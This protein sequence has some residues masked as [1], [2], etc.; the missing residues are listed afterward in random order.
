M[1]GLDMDLLANLGLGDYLDENKQDS[2]EEDPSY[3]MTYEEMRKQ[4]NM[5]GQ[6]SAVNKLRGACN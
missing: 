3:N 2:G 1:Y 4:Y 6:T 5:D